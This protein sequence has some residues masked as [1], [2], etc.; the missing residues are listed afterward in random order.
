MEAQHRVA[1]LLHHLI[2]IEW[3]LMPS[4]TATE[5]PQNKAIALCPTQSATRQTLPSS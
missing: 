2:L 1:A 5:E 4:S 3:E